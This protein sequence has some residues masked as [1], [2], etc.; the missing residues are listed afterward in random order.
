MT[1]IQPCIIKNTPERRA[2]LEEMGVTYDGYYGRENDFIVVGY[3]PYS[4]NYDTLNTCPTNVAYHTM[5]DGYKHFDYVNCG[6]DEDLFFALAALRD[7][8]DVNQWF[9]LDSHMGSINYSDSYIPAGSLMICDRD[10][11]SDI[12]LVEAH[13]ATVEELIDHFRNRKL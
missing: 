8:T 11:W 1:Y 10:N 6:D 7:D 3:G 2:K 4:N 5:W 13:K 9:V 12:G